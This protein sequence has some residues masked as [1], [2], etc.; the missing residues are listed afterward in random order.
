M[1]ECLSGKISKAVIGI[2]FSIGNEE[3]QFFILRGSD[4]G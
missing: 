3:K 2:A 1:D 4:P